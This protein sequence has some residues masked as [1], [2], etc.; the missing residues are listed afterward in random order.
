MDAVALKKQLRKELNET[1]KA[2]TEEEVKVKSAIMLGHWA[3]HFKVPPIVHLFQPIVARREPDAGLFQQYI[4]LHHPDTRI[5]IPVVD[6]ITDK[7]VHVELTQDIV[8]VNNRWGIPEP[9]APFKAVTCKLPDMVLVPLLGF[10]RQG[11]RLGYGKGHY[12]RF[13]ACT[14]PDC[15]KVGLAFELSH[16]PSLPTEPH[17]LRLDAVVTEERV[18]VF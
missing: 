14:R 13:L 17:D 12:D 6:P 4:R 9:V 1:R 16:V 15:L 8:L 3:S 18:Y 10:D 7:L 2:L 11:N 5:L